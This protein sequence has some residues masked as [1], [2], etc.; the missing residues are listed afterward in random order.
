LKKIETQRKKKERKKE[1]NK[2]IMIYLQKKNGT[3]TSNL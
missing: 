2:E 1:K 3:N